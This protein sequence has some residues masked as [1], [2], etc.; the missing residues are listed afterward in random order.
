MPVLKR[1]KNG[2][3]EN[4][5]GISEHTHTK[6][7]ITDLQEKVYTQPDEPVNAPVGSVWV[8]TDE[9][10][11]FGGGGTADAV[12]YIPQTLTEEQQ[13][14]ARANM[15][16]YYS[17]MGIGTVLAE[18]TVM[19]DPDAGVGLIPVNFTVEGGQ[20]YTIK[21]NGVEYVTP[22]IEI[23]GIWAFGNLGALEEGL[24][25][26]NDPFVLM[27]N[28][29][30]EAIYAWRIIPLDGSEMVTLSI[31]GM[32][33]VVIPIPEKFMP[34]LRGQKKI[35]LNVDN[36][37]ASI[38]SD[39]VG[40]MDMLELQN[41]IIVLDH[42]LECCAYSIVKTTQT[43]EGYPDHHYFQVHYVMGSTFKGTTWDRYTCTY[44]PS[45]ST[46]TD[47][48]VDHSET[49][50][51]VYAACGYADRWYKPDEILHAG[52][53]LKSTE[54]NKQFLLTVDDNGNITATE[55]TV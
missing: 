30:D 54:S 5:S 37:I 32:M 17:E 43:A 15:G 45:Y 48:I 21:Y 2:V 28:R 40:D 26:T 7:D 44:E 23:E 31:T 24:P 34:E 33:E 55:Q 35:I 19:I 50:P 14:Q 18:T 25:T 6:D 52:L 1:F 8:D 51:K 47:G 4:V 42:G 53:L 16:L 3:W 11:G 20:E 13:M 10:V 41:S 46:L 36:E 49:D 22:C 29:V 12:Q 39:A 9:D 27:Y 38:S